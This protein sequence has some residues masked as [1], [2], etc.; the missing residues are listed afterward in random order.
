MLQFSQ[1]EAQ[2]KYFS[3]YDLLL[4]AFSR[5][6]RVHKSSESLKFIQSCFEKKLTP[7]FVELS[8]TL[9]EIIVLTPVEIRKTYIRKLLR[10]R[11]KKILQLIT[12]ESLLKNFP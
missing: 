10:E 2:R 1:Q 12:H 11:D 5:C 4:E 9:M 7:K 8:T 3:D 6:K